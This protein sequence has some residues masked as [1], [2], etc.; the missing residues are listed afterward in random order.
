MCNSFA[1]WSHG[2]PTSIDQNFSV[3]RSLKST[4]VNGKKAESIQRLWKYRLCLYNNSTA[5]FTQIFEKKKRPE[6]MFLDFAR[7]EEGFSMKTDD[8]F[9]GRMLANIF[10]TGK[11]YKQSETKELFVL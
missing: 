5:S 9:E 8:S 2:V 7:D 10:F 1:K 6:T 11:T 3:L 4:N